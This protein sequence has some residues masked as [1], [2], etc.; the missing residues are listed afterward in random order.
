M[1]FAIPTGWCGAPNTTI[2]AW[3]APFAAGH[4]FAYLATNSTKGCGSNVSVAAPGHFSARNG[5]TSLVVNASTAGCRLP[6][7]IA[8]YQIRMGIGFSNLTVPASGF[9]NLT[10]AWLDGARGELVVG[11]SSLS[12]P[13]VAPS[14]AGAALN[15]NVNLVDSHGTVWHTT[16]PIIPRAAH[17]DNLGN[18]TIVV[19]HLNRSVVLQNPTVW[20]A[21]GTSYTLRVFLGV[22]LIDTLNLAGSPPPGM[23]VYS[24][25]HLGGGIAPIRLVTVTLTT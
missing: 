22:H 21:K 19:G 16:R 4:P 15:L 8:E 7:S 6:L 12:Y 24:S 25:V 9:Y 10:V 2:Y 14:G 5:S 1:S 3:S 18:S 17:L 13:A 11:T 23:L 20:L